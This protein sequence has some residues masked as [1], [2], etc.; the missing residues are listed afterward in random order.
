[1]PQNYPHVMRANPTIVGT[2]VLVSLFLFGG[3]HRAWAQSPPV[4]SPGP[5]MQQ[6]TLSIAGGSRA[7]AG[8]T[9]LVATAGKVSVF[10]RTPGTG[11]WTHATDLTPDDGAA[12]FGGGVSFDGRRAIV[13][14]AG[15][16]Y[17][18]RRQ[19]G[20]ANAWQ[21][22]ARLVP[23]DGTARF[24]AS[25]AIDGR[26]ALVGAVGDPQTNVAGSVF[27]FKR[28]AGSWQE[29]A[30]LEPSLVPMI[31]GNVRFGFG[32]HVDVSGDTAIVS[33]GFQD[34]GTA[35]LYD[36]NQG[37]PDN[38]GFVK[39]L[40]ALPLTPAVAID[41]DTAVMGA[42][43]FLPSVRIFGRNEGDPT[44]GEF[45]RRLVERT[46]RRCA[47]GTVTSASI[48]G[49]DAIVGAARGGSSIQIRARNEGGLNAWGLV[50]RFSVGGTSPPFHFLSLVAIDGDT[51]LLDADLLPTT[52]RFRFSY[53]M[54]MA[55]ECATG[56]TC[57]R[58]PLNNVAG[59]CQRA[60]VDHP[61][62]DDLITQ[63]EVTAETQGSRQIISATFT[64]TS[65]T[66]VENPFFEVTE[67][68]GR[69]VVV[70]RGRGTRPSRRYPLA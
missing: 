56:A 23:G 8:D 68:T 57:P 50:S 27:V 51:V 69:N 55:T 40:G 1:M 70:Q 38:W 67:L 17:V 26:Y 65:A 11:L 63:S 54:W 15:A 42:G 36:R 52:T 14:A 13:E 9:A 24:G 66:A 58:D 34:F 18:F 45:R 16:A 59:G 62:L 61:V 47:A 33:A 12:G 22:V 64:N 41:G 2:L 30:K 25:V 28:T 10:E 53:P 5:F 37:G 6:D 3:D 35:F 29:I 44:P 46:R 21:Q 19:E 39:N 31:L 48:S 49:D 4:I 20:G 32:L 43:E 7:I 60:S